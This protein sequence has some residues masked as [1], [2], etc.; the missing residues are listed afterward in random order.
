MTT[1][2]QSTKRKLFLLQLAEELGNVSKACK[3]M[4]YH[5]DTFY[6]VRRAFQVGGVS[7]LVEERRGPRNPHPN[8][9]APE[10]EQKILDYALNFPTHGPQRVSNELR[11]SGTE[12][13]PSGVREVWLHNGIETRYKRL[14]RLE[15][16]A[17]GDTIVLTENQIRL[18]ERHSVELRCR[19]VGGHR[20]AANGRLSRNPGDSGCR[21][22]TEF[23]HTGA[24][25]VR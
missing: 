25:K 15:Q 21:V 9:V 4:G 10:I 1:L 3:L 14:M 19:H 24:S 13:S 12:V 23:V 7:A 16:H 22:I 20:A 18:L 5:R 2:S 6:E 17:Q 8:R 11:L